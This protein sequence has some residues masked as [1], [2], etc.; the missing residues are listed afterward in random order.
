MTSTTE[1]RGEDAALAEAFDAVRG[2]WGDV[3]KRADARGD[4][5]YSIDISCGLS[6]QDA[7]YYASISYG[8][9]DGRGRRLFCAADNCASPAAAMQ[10]LYAKLKHFSASGSWKTPADAV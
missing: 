6:G 1:S 4:A 7:S 3:A 10:S 9:Q 2:L 8:T 5:S